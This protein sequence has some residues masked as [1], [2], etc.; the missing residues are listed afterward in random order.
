MNAG[1]MVIQYYL[2]SK[3]RGTH[4]IHQTGKNLDL[5]IP[6]ATHSHTALRMDANHIWY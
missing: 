4:H 2:A 1:I 5:L 6:N 3:V